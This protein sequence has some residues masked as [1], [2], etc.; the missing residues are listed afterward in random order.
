[1]PS[2]GS[3]ADDPAAKVYPPLEEEGTPAQ[4]KKKSSLPGDGSPKAEVD[5][6]TEEEGPRMEDKK[7]SSLLGDG[8][9]DPAAEVDPP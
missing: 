9:D 1:M 3:G 8:G 7:K 5:P 2:P 6:L 4:D